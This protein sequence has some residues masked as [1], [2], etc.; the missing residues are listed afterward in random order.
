MVQSNI[1]TIVQPFIFNMPF[2]TC[3]K[4]MHTL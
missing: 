1:Y 4:V 3:W 2:L